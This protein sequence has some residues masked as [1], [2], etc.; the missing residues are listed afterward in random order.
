MKFENI[1]G[2]GLDTSF[3]ELKKERDREEE[4][5]IREEPLQKNPK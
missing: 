3:S 5:N 4:D 2:K 1:A